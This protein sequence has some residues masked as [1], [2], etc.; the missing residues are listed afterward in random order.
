M[1]KFNFSRP[2]RKKP[3][4]PQQPAPPLMPMS[5]AH[6][7]LGSTPLSIDSSSIH[8]TPQPTI[9][10]AGSGYENSTLDE[11]EFDLPGGQARI[12]R[13]DAELRRERGPSPS[14]MRLS[15][16]ADSVGFGAMALP[17][18]LKKAQSSSTIK[19]WH[20][21]SKHSRSLS[22]QASIPIMN[23]GLSA[24]THH[25]QDTDSANESAKLRKKPPNLEFSSGGP[26]PRLSK[27]GSDTFNSNLSNSSTKTPT[28]SSPFPT[29]SHRQSDLRG[30]FKRRTKDS[31]RSFA[32]EQSPPGTGE[33]RRMTTQL[34]D[35]GL[36]TLYNHYEQMTFRHGLGDDSDLTNN[37]AQKTDPADSRTE[38]EWREVPARQNLDWLHKPLSES[39]EPKAVAQSDYSSSPGDGARSVSSRHTRTSR[40]SRITDGGMQEADF[41]EKSVLLLSSDSEED[42]D[43]R[44]STRDHIPLPHPTRPLPELPKSSR[45]RQPSGREPS[46]A[47]NKKT[48]FAPAN[49]YIAITNTER[50]QRLSP[51]PSRL[52][53]PYR[54]GARAP[55]PKPSLGST[56]STGSGMTSQIGFGAEDSPPV[57]VLPA[58]RPSQAELDRQKALAQ[59]T[60]GTASSLRRESLATSSDQPDEPTP[61]LSPSSVNFYLR[62]ARS[63]IDDSGSHGRVMTL[64]RQEE[65]LISALRKKTQAMREK[66]QLGPSN[67]PP[68]DG[69][70]GRRHVSTPSQVMV[71]DS[72]L[73]FDFPAPPS[74]S[75]KHRQ[76]GASS[77][78]S[79]SIPEHPYSEDEHFRAP[80][81]LTTDTSSERASFVSSTRGPDEYSEQH[82][83]RVYL[84][85]GKQHNGQWNQIGSDG[86]VVE[87]PTNSSGF[88]AVSWD[89]PEDKRTSKLKN[90]ATRQQPQAES[91]TSSPKLT[92][93]S[94]DGNEDV[95]RPDS[96]I[97]NETFPQPRP[98]RRAAMNTARLSAVGFVR[99]DTEPGWWGDDD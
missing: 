16:L 97:S 94:E 7:I 2:A 24:K 37:T 89:H 27:K 36:S 14:N 65:M 80:S 47:P 69:R 51:S 28:L 10:V 63:S 9:S 33:A 30:M 17:G 13:A 26:T 82:D 34:S 99:R 3:Q 70:Q 52:S 84:D 88:H 38:A 54:D 74:H 79:A 53:L 62:S 95:P 25:F 23:N 5:K 68:L 43:G 12:P 86:R 45:P 32:T 40:A 46:G 59:L 6:K 57:T 90:K 55:S 35:N 11:L 75:S 83:I 56:N 44:S 48:S 64:T 71:T 29:P 81:R 60:S 49:T 39:H 92:R 85:Q 20:D 93:L 18:T 98:P 19:S 91:V 41:Q 50:K 77:L 96:P 21:K 4:E 66:S 76:S 67:K 72:M 87:D 15:A 22:R 1:R 61:P 78:M 58:R 73:D 31:F 8:S 42:D